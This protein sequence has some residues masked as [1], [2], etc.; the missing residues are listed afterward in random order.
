MSSIDL[1]E[2]SLLKYRMK[3]YANWG[4]SFR[5]YGNKTKSLS[6]WSGKWKSPIFFSDIFIGDWKNSIIDSDWR[7]ELNWIELNWIEG[8]SVHISMR[9]DPWR[10][11]WRRTLG[12]PE[13]YVEVNPVILRKSTSGVP[14]WNLKEQ[15]RD[16][17]TP[18]HQ[19]TRILLE[20][21]QC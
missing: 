21:K 11:I 8:E 13:L 10:H 3:F 18:G 19:D 20:V 4:K 2:I 14:R 16:T 5:A 17:R 7:I 9:N 15:R 1:I 6:R 12:T